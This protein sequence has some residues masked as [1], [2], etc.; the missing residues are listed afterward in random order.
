MATVTNTLKLPDGSTPSTGRVLIELVSSAGSPKL[1]GW[2]P[3]DNTI[4][5][6][7]NPTVASDG[8]WSA[9]LVP[10][11][12]IDPPGTA[13]KIT[14]SVGRVRYVHHI[15]V[16]S[17]GGTVHDLLVDAPASL[18]SSALAAHQVAADPHG[19]RAY[20]A[21]LVD[22][23]SGVTNATT[24]RANLQAFPGAIRTFHIKD[25]GA[26]RYT[27]QAA[28]TSGTDSTQAIIDATDAAAAAGG[29]TVVFDPG[30]YRVS[31]ALKTTRNGNAQITLP[32]VSYLGSKVSIKWHCH[33]P[34]VAEFYPTGSQSTSVAGAI[35]VSTLTAQTYSASHGMPSVVGG[36]TPEGCN[37][38]NYMSTDTT[39]F[40]NIYLT[41]HGI[42]VRCQPNPTLTAWD[43]GLVLAGHVADAAVDTTET[44]SVINNEPT[45]AHAWG[46]IL[47][48]V[49]NNVLNRVGNFS[50]VGF[51]AGLGFS[52]H[53]HV[54]N[55]QFAYCRVG[56][57]PMAVGT[58][59]AALLQSV[60][61]ERCVYGLAWV[62]PSTGVGNAGNYGKFR[63]LHYDAEHVST[64][65]GLWWDH[66]WDV[67]DPNNGFVGKVFYSISGGAGDTLDVSGASELVLENYKTGEINRLGLGPAVTTGLGADT[68]GAITVP[69]NCNALVPLKINGTLYYLPA[70]LPGPVTV[71]SHTFTA[72]NSTSAIP[73][74]DTGS[75]GSALSGTWGIASNKAYCVTSTGGRYQ[76]AWETG[77]ADFTYE[78]DITLSGTTTADCGLIFRALDA[79]NHYLV[80]FSKSGAADS[81]SLWRNISGSYTSIGSFGSAG[82]T[83]GTTYH[84]KIECAGSVKRIYIDGTLR[85]TH[86]LATALDAYTKVGL[87]VDPAHDNG[88]A[89]RFDNVLVKA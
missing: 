79:S 63:I 81:V 49:N 31:G 18:P 36:P 34:A 40:T 68:A 76:Y 50:V 21:A 69:A 1:A 64:D 71:L 42:R 23:L 54:E 78:A 66:L 52:E 88:G 7:A 56:L 17:G 48:R 67:Y 80:E 43:L 32:A 82:L 16:G 55:V 47:P 72:G 89:S 61:V 53:A 45:A 74:P 39:M 46:M 28:A 37:A 73:T 83:L 12:D 77:V 41:V 2:G 9:S 19:D 85:I 70:Y 5:D 59:H 38:A 4:L 10:N 57:V 15:E 44:G 30:F 14:E 87:D 13:Y 60:S 75:A 6:I 20:S 84:V 29:G 24:A 62:H 51:Y 26:V 27:T 22:D 65:S 8:T 86:S 25:Y 11:A 33:E 3:T 35:L 58:G